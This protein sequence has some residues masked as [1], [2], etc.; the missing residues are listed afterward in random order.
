MIAEA[1]QILQLLEN[2]QLIYSPN[3][4]CILDNMYYSSD[5]NTAVF[6]DLQ[7]TIYYDIPTKTHKLRTQLYKKPNA[8]PSLIHNMS[9]VPQ[10]IKVGTIKGELIRRLIACN[11]K[12]IFNNEVKQFL[13]QLRKIGYNKSVLYECKIAIKF[14]QRQQYIDNNIQAMYAK[15]TNNGIRDKDANVNNIHDKDAKMIYFVKHFD[16]KLDNHQVLYELFNQYVSHAW[17]DTKTI[18]IANKLNCKLCT[19]IQ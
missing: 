19:I 18:K 7:I 16:N 15:I 14:E 1:Q 13:T 6:L 3:I 10:A 5:G 2:L 17:P 9:N 12:Q 4:K 8:I 11:K